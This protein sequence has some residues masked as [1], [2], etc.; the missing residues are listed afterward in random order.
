MISLSSTTK[1][2]SKTQEVKNDQSFKH[3]KAQE[4]KNDQSFKLYKAQV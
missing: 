3:Y 2:K 4:D 1:H